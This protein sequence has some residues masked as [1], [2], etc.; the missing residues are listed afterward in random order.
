[1]SRQPRN[2]ERG[3]EAHDLQL[4]CQC[5]CTT[6]TRMVAWCAETKANQP[7]NRLHHPRDLMESEAIHRVI[8][9]CHYHPSQ[10]LFLFPPPPSP[11]SIHPFNHPLATP[12][13]RRPL[14]SMQ[15]LLTAWEM[16]QQPTR[17][18]D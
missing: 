9:L 11:P 13:S 10:P 17:L 12:S 18:A 4:P 14:N 1:M 3:R 5:R 15:A 7:T 8:Y 16:Q 6:I 2:T